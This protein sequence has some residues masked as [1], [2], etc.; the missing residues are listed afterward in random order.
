[1]CVRHTT[2]A[3]LQALKDILM[4]IGELGVGYGHNISARFS[5]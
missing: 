1:M 4:I 2:I 3:K 5:Q